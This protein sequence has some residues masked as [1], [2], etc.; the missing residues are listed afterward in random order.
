MSAETAVRAAIQSLVSGRCYPEERIEGQGLPAITFSRLSGAPEPLLS[1]A[2][3][4]VQVELEVVAWAET[5][6]AATTLAGQIQTAVL[7]L[8]VTY[9][10]TTESGYD[11]DARIYFFA[12]NMVY[13]EG[14]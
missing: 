12:I 10:N 14:A 13:W 3:T 5:L 8:G 2:A 11:E 6:D 9:V 1:G 7:A 4:L